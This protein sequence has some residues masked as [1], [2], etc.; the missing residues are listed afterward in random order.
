MGIAATT[1][2]SII[3]QRDM[4]KN[5]TYSQRFDGTEIHLVQA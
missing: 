4:S 5:D 2:K 3:E 1:T